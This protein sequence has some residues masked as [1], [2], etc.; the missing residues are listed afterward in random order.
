MDCVG[1]IHMTLKH[2]LIY[3]NCIGCG[4]LFL[5]SRIRAVETARSYAKRAEAP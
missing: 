5:H 3:L 1:R 4:A 2:W